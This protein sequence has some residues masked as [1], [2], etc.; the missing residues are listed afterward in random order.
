M[1][2]PDTSPDIQPQ[3][4]CSE[5]QL[6]DLCDLDTCCHKRGRFCSDPALLSRFEKIADDEFRTSER[7]VLEE[8]DDSEAGDGYDDEDERFESEYSDND[9]DDEWQDEE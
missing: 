3:R 7:Y 9:E 1:P 5:V 2:D 6:F 4:L 8:P